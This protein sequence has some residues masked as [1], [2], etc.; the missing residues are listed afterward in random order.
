MS[1]TDLPSECPSKKKQLLVLS[2]SGLL[3]LLHVRSDGPEKCNLHK[4]IR[5]LSWHCSF[6]DEA[7]AKMAKE[8]MIVIFI[9]KVCAKLIRSRNVASNLHYF[10][11][12]TELSF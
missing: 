5:A 10:A 11:T 4:A 8:T 12:L 3:C 2:K 6:G 1:L 9:L 7:N